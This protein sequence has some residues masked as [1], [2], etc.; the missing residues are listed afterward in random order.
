MKEKKPLILSLIVSLG[1]GALSAL[2]T[3]RST[4]LY[5]SVIQPP[6]SPPAWVFPVVWT[7]LY[8]LMGVAAYLVWRSDD[9]GRERALTFYGAQ[10]LLNFF[11]PQI[12]FNARQFGFALVWIIVLLALVVLT[13]RA[14]ARIDKTAGW[15]MLPY[16]LWVAFA[17]YL[18]AGVWYLN[19]A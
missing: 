18:N 6:L 19:R 14:F 4:E 2:L 7:A 5:G 1:T 13:T 16:V 17:A 15:L 9:P 11:W 12:F 3:R 10:L 8:I